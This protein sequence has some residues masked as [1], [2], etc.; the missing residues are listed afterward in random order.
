MCHLLL[1]SLVSLYVH[2]CVTCFVSQVSRG[3]TWLTSSPWSWVELG[4]ASIVLQ[5]R[6]SGLES[7][8]VYGYLYCY[9]C[10][11]YEIC[12]ILKDLGVIWQTSEPISVEC[13]R[14]MNG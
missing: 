1:I 10:V 6:L 4:I 12:V 13:I 9:V 5:I 2:L 3:S 11:A 7:L 14:G 8:C